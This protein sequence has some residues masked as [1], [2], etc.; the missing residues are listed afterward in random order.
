VPTQTLKNITV[1]LTSG[2]PAPRAIFGAP[3][4]H[5]NRGPPYNYWRIS[6]L[7]SYNRDPDYCILK[8]DRNP[9]MKILT[10]NVSI[11]CVY[12]LP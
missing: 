10:T 1:E 8:E 12:G 4:R 6:S 11:L 7:I 2:R 5:D 3:V 9:F